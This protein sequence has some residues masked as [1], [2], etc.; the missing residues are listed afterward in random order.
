VRLVGFAALAPVPW[1]NGG[2]LTREIAGA[3]GARLSLADIERDGPFSI[4]EGLDR[5][6]VVVQGAV[7]LSFGPADVVRLDPGVAP[8]EFAG[9]HAPQAAPGAPGCRALNLLVERGRHGGSLRRETW[10][11]GRRVDAQDLAGVF[12]VHVQDGLLG[13]G[14]A[15]AR[16]GD[17]LVG[18]ERED[19]IDVLADS[20]VLLARV[21]TRFD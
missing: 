9:E 16:A 20:V 4:F 1:R 15:R 12:A 5:I 19:A 14:D 2:G 11:A 8:L 18:D 13:C 7:T 17:T 10:P 3:P 21:A 6:F